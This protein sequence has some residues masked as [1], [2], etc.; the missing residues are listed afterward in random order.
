MFRGKTTLGVPVAALIPADDPILAPRVDEEVKLLDVVLVVELISFDDG[1]TGSETAVLVGLK[2][3]EIDVLML[4]VVLVKTV[5]DVA[6][7]VVMLLVDV[8]NA[9]IVL[10][11]GV[12]MAMVL[13]KL[14]ERTVE[15]AA[16]LLEFIEKLTPGSTGMVASELAA[17][18]VLATTFV[19]EPGVALNTDE[20]GSNGKVPEAELG[21][22]T[23]TV[24]LEVKKTEVRFDNV[25]DVVGGLIKAVVDVPPDDIPAELVRVGLPGGESSSDGILDKDEVT[26]ESGSPDVAD[27]APGGGDGSMLENEKVGP[28][29]VTVD[30]DSN[31]EEESPPLASDDDSNRLDDKELPEIKVTGKDVAEIVVVRRELICVNVVTALVSSGADCGSETVKPPLD[32]A[33]VKLVGINRLPIVFVDGGDGSGS[34][35]ILLMMVVTVLVEVVICPPGSVDVSVTGDAVVTIGADVEGAFSTVVEIS[36]TTIVCPPG[37]VLVTVTSTFE[38]VGVTTLDRVGETTTSREVVRKV[39]KDV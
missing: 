37:R 35:E 38:I 9:T 4:N 19:E 39:T 29:I 28:G 23:G 10:K 16:L 20:E 13:V 27:I 34:G 12:I 30:I 6:S 36:V 21:F 5:D 24:K 33:V 14:P 15:A 7:G 1:S 17:G 32:V 11:G 3:F 22:A 2:I 25:S 18:G 26:S 8:L 31:A